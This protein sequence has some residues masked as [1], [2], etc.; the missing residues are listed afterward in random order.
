MMKKYIFA[1]ALVFSTTVYAQKELKNLHVGNRIDWFQPGLATHQ[2]YSIQLVSPLNYGNGK[3]RNLDMQTYNLASAESRAQLGRDVQ[4]LLEIYKL[5]KEE[6][7]KKNE[8][9]A[10]KD[11]PISKDI[12]VALKY[13]NDLN[14]QLTASFV[15]NNADPQLV[16]KMYELSESINM[17]YKDIIFPKIQLGKLISIIFGLYNSRLGEHPLQMNPDEKEIADPQD[18][19]FWQKPESVTS[20]DTYAGFGRN[21]LPDYSKTVFTY[22]KAKTGFGTH[23]GFRVELGDQEY[24]IRLGEETRIAPFSSR[25]LNAL[26]FNSLTIDYA[27]ELRVKYSKKI[28]REF[29]SRAAIPFELAIG[30]L[31]I[32]EIQRKNFHDPFDY[33]IKA[34]MKDGRTLTGAELKK[35]LMSSRHRKATNEDEN[36][37]SEVEEQIDEVV[38]SPA[39][40]EKLEDSL[41]SVGPWS[42]DE[43]RHVERR[44]I[45]GYGLLAAWL[46]QFD[47]RTENTRLMLVSD[48]NGHRVLRH[49]VSD[50]GSGLGRAKPLFN[51]QTDDIEKF[52]ETVLKSS[53]RNDGQMISRK[54]QT[55]TTNKCFEATNAQDAKWMYKYINLLTEK[56]IKSA[57]KASGF[58]ETEINE[59]Y[60][61]LMARKEN[62]RQVLKIN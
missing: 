46:G 40:V 57:L 4:K 48:N 20:N 8:S 3:S 13:L 23:A 29:N 6:D 7:D 15:A 54:Y 55:Y 22:K 24:K 56:Q 58:N 38:F 45:R 11:F 18:S 44:D 60:R 50:V 21:E 61:K 35:S 36:Y 1:T 51:A 19:S 16:E 52:R 27:P 34:I 33:V 31:E 53:S 26:G 28:F 41:V 30:S 49:Y 17:N 9:K 62:I 12:K 37:I 32:L 42:W 5:E 2:R 43:I 39:S 25:L 59:V 47:A 10:T 14:V